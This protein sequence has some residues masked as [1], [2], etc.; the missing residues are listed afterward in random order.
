[1][2]QE[3]IHPNKIRE[4][5]KERGVSQQDIADALKVTQS[6]IAQMEKRKRNRVLEKWF[7]VA[8]Y[9]ETSIYDLYGWNPK[10]FPK[11]T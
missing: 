8:D 1:M 6:D 9:L 11:K 5:R 10:D 2:E 3:T 7:R 4:I